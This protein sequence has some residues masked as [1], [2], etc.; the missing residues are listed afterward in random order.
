VSKSRSATRLDPGR[1]GHIEIAAQPTAPAIAEKRFIAAPSAKRLEGQGVP[2]R[3]S[4]GDCSGCAPPRLSDYQRSFGQ[5][6]PSP[7]D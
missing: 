7:V 3:L 5:K 1:H 2:V 6:T 4:S